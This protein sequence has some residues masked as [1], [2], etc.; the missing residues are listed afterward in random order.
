MGIASRLGIPSLEAIPHQLQFVM[1]E[2]LP[3]T[4]FAKGLTLPVLR[5]RG[6]ER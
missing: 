1:I 2:L 3:M 6:S 4:G 5:F